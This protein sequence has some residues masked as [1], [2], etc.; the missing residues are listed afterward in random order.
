V[1]ACRCVG[2][3]DNLFN[4]K[5]SCMRGVPPRSDHE[6]SKSETLRLRLRVRRT[7]IRRHADTSPDAAPEVQIELRNSAFQA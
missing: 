2:E 3:H 7:P 5:L 1:S 6:E 4:G